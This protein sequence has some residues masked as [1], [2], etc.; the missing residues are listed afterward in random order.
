MKELKICEIFECVNYVDSDITSINSEVD[1]DYITFN[2]IMKEKKSQVL[3]NTKYDPDLSYFKNNYFNLFNEQE[4]LNKNS[5]NPNQKNKKRFKSSFDFIPYEKAV[6]FSFSRIFL[7]KK[8]V[9]FKRFKDFSD[10]MERSLKDELD[11]DQDERRIKSLTKCI[12]LIRK[13]IEFYER[14]NEI[15]IYGIDNTENFNNISNKINHAENNINN[16]SEGNE[17]ILPKENLE[18]LS[19]IEDGNFQRD[20]LINSEIEFLKKNL[21][22]KNYLFFYQEQTGDIYLL[23]PV[24]FQ[25]L[26]KEYKIEGNLPTKI[27][28]SNL[29]IL[30]KKIL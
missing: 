10:D 12:E 6:E 14:E 30:L 29:Y 9:L 3:Y 5:V 16:I 25:M 15:Y 21:D 22:L 18:N 24:N 26:L 17:I 23:H 13:D 2:L 1:T 27:T 28:V 7:T 11:S 8:E 4:N 19:I 20:N